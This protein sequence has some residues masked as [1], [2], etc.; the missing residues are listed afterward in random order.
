MPLF[1]RKQQSFMTK[2]PKTGAS[3]GPASPQQL[4]QWFKAIDRDG[5]GSLDSTELQRALALGNLHFSLQATSHMIRMHDTKGN[6][7]VN[8]T[9]FEKLHN[10]LTNVQRSF[11]Q[12]DV[13][14]SGE[15]DMGEVQQA[16]SSAGFQLDQPAFMALFQA[17]DP[18][19][20]HALSLPEYIGMTLFLQSATATFTAFDA[21]RSGRITL[22]FNQWIYAASN[23]L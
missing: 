7:T 22:D 18:D 9:E 20:S 8:F 17:F 4:Q 6:G 13:D 14:R 2:A 19:K 10:F 11:T 16:L 3:S 21:Q 1:G 23:V 5:N 15:L 12:F